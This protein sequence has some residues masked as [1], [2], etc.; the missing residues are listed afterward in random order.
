MTEFR[1]C[2]SMEVVKEDSSIIARCC[3]IP[4]YPLVVKKGH[5]TVIE[6]LDGNEYIDFFSSAAAINVGHSHPKVVK[7]IQDQS[8]ELIHYT[9]AYMY[10]EPA[11]KLAKRLVEITPGQSGKRV[12]FGL[13]GSDANDGMI[14][15]ARAYTGRSKIISFEHSYHGSTYG[16]L[17]MSAISLN[18]RKKIG[19]LLPE[20]YHFQYPECYR[21]AYKRKPQSCSL[22]CLSAMENAFRHYLPPEEVAAV[23]IE[24]MAGDAGLL[25]PPGKY[26]RRLYD[27]CRT[28]GILFTV[29]EVQ[30]GFG[31]TGKWF[32]IENFDIEPDMLAVAK[33]IASGMPL[34]AVVGKEEILQELE[35]VAHAFTTAANPVSCRAALATIEV[36]E[37]E[38]LMSRA[39]ATGEYIKKRFKKMKV[40]YE[41]IGDIRGIGLSIGVD[42]VV[43]RYTKDKNH[44]AAVKICYRCWQKGLILMFFAGSVLRIQP[45]LVIAR[46]QVDR[47][48][49]I[50]E[51]TI[52]EYVAGKISDDMLSTVKGW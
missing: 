25:L 41:I 21:C 14:K 48:L 18:M 19:P 11:V 33:S 1:I 5:G 9:I 15:A 26:L 13:S 12:M 24:P 38:K 7:A 40:K 43:N 20:V 31:R 32:S 46:E 27:I 6:D 34:S 39:K 4:Y 35:P 8:D 23:I 37:D 3:R 17:S 42:L 45:P 36:I 49:D 28:N 10:H 29:D 16:S 22:E 52:K 30:Q 44:E 50:I 51:E 2:K 47:G